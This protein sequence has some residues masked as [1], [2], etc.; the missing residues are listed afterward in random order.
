MWTAFDQ[1]IK[2]CLIAVI[3]QNGRYEKFNRR[4]NTKIQ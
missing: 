4:E 2:C 1:Q 3:E